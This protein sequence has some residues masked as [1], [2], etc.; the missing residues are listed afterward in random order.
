M[1]ARAPSR[2][3]H[4]FA[5][6]PIFFFQL[7]GFEMG[8]EQIFICNRQTF[9]ELLVAGGHVHVEWH[10]EELERRCC[11][12][13]IFLVFNFWNVPA[14][15]P[16]NP[17]FLADSS[18]PADGFIFDP[19]AIANVKVNLFQTQTKNRYALSF[20]HLMNHLCDR[21][22]ESP[23]FRKVSQLDFLMLLAAEHLEV[24]GVKSSTW[25]AWDER[26]L[27]RVS[28]LGLG[29]VLWIVYQIWFQR[30]SGV[31]SNICEN[32]FTMILVL[33]VQYVYRYYNLPVTHL[34]VSS[35]CNN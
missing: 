3:F 33:Q 30:F 28:C 23:A 26:A 13:L 32:Y 27:F 29:S 14:G 25:E 5:S 20:V 18:Q 21:F 7:R 4:P 17:T 2:R 22:C 10:I 12:S 8:F 35:Y 9:V 19:F 1:A 24:T 15:C 6:S 34:F 11:H 16:G 31:V